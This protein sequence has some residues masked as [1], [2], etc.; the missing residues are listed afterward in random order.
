MAIRQVLPPLPASTPLVDPKTGF[1][2]LAFSQWW[3]QITQN[4]DTAFGEIDDSAAAIAAN[5]AAI[6]TK[7][8][9][10]RLINTT[11]PIAGGGDLSADRTLTHA[12]TA[13]TPGSYTNANITVDQKGHLTAAASGAGGTGAYAFAWPDQGP[14]VANTGATPCLGVYFTPAVD[15]VVAGL[16]ATSTTVVGATYRVAIYQVSAA[17][18]ISAITA[19]SANIAT[20]GAVTGASIGSNFAAPVTLVAG[21]HYVAT[22]RRTDLLDTTVVGVFGIA[23]ALLPTY[24]SLPSTFTSTE[25]TKFATIAKKNPAVADTFTLGTAGYYSIGFR[26]SC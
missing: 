13:V 7:V 19:D 18:V 2:T 5:A 1:P 23:T 10:T 8:P 4:G 12:D 22:F 15:M 6:L 25:Q 17:G 26:Y 20:P 11:T 14:N 24:S 21:N 3:Q 9:L 16:W